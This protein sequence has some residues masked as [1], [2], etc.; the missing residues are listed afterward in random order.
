MPLPAPGIVRKSGATSSCHGRCHKQFAKDSSQPC[1]AKVSA[2][3]L[4]A[5]SGTTPAGAGPSTQLALGTP[6]QLPL[7]PPAARPTG[8]KRCGPAA[9]VEPPCKQAR[10]TEHAPIDSPAR[11]FSKRPRATGKPPVRASS[12]R[13]RY[14][15][16][17]S[18]WDVLESIERL[19]AARSAPL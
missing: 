2:T 15:A 10:L 8:S 12:K 9:S 17:E 5:S 11:N 7:D 18:Q 3:S 4:P 14:Q 16:R 13:P 6:V 19:R 1:F